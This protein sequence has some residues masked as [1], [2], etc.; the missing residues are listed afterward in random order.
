MPKKSIPKLVN[1]GR[2]VWILLAGNGPINGG[3]GWLLRRLQVKQWRITRFIDDLGWRMWYCARTAWRVSSVEKWRLSAWISLM[4]IVD[5]WLSDD[6]MIRCFMFSGRDECWILPLTRTMP[7]GS[8][9]GFR[10]ARWDAVGT[11]NFFRHLI[12]SSKKCRWSTRIMKRNASRSSGALRK[13]DE[14]R[15]WELMCRLLTNR[16]GSFYSM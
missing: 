16:S 3:S 9:K 5:S 7:Y 13:G 2:W 4:T 1:G 14:I 15:F 11:G 12:S 10:L 6:M 8:R